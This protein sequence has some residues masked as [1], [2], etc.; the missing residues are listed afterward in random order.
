MHL[1]EG[2]LRAAAPVPAS[3]ASA[4]ARSSCSS[5]ST[6]D[7]LPLYAGIKRLFDPNGI[8]NPGQGV[9]RR[10]ERRCRITACRSTRPGK[11]VCVGLNYRD[12]AEES[13]MELPSRPLLFAEWPN[14][15]I[16]PGAADRAARSRR[17]DV[18]YEAE[19]GVVIGTRAQYG[20][21]RRRARPRRRLLLRQR[22]ER[23]G[24]PVRGRPVDAREVVRHVRP[25][26]SDRCPPTRCPTRRRWESAAC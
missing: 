15:L 3:T 25:G 1:V 10:E 6:A 24:H 13:G 4:Q 16:G 12:H 5:A 20:V 2:A 18:D 8:M 22:G 19:L 7:L 17:T 9:H 14:S 26:R 23:A 11:I 21:G